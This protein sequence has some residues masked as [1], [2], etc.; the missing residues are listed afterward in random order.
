MTLSFGRFEQAW[1]RSDTLFA[2][3]APEALLEQPI[4]LRQPFIF[5][6]GHLPA[7][8]WNHLGR[9][10]LGEPPFDPR[11][12]DLF[13]R[14]ID[15]V[16]TDVYRPASADAWP[17]AED[18][19]AYRDGVRERL[20]G[21]WPRLRQAR[22]GLAAAAMVLE[23]ELMHHETLLYMIQQLPPELK[24]GKAA[25]AD[26]AAAPGRAARPVRVPA[27]RARL[28]ARPGTID[29]GWDNEFSAHEVDVPAFAIDDLPVRNADVLEFVEAGG[30]TQDRWWGE[31]DWAWRTRRGLS[32]PL[33]WRR[34]P[35]GWIQRGPF[36]DV[37]FAS[38]ADWPASVSW[39][40]AS[41]YARWQGARLPTEAELQRAAHGDPDGGWR[42]FPWGEEPPRPE[43]ANL[44]FTRWSPVASGACPAGASAWGIQEL[45]G[46]GWEW[47]C[48]TFGPFPGFQAMARYPGY[49]R[50]FFDG[51]HYVLL[52]ASWATDSALVRRS[53]RNWFQP[54]YP[55]V[56]SKFR[57]VR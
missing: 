32:H 30:Y 43:H 47:T 40:E 57:L 10:G 25:L 55:Y 27:G 8:A 31:G 34:T 49:S 45:V 4:P 44:G 15:P 19:R 16:D 9:G 17:P 1:E 36:A 23:H 5:Y 2:F 22:D 12:D 42:S 53:F 3:L 21:E 37:P 24:H 39:A 14:G 38:A 26:E 41:A 28:G 18:A 51:R 29:F 11:L 50:D 56:F 46:N 35:S 52:G 48:T 33:N 6:L 7:F 13:A 54:H 20:S